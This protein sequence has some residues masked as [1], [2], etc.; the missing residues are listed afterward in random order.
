M[1]IFTTYTRLCFSATWSGV[2]KETW[3]PSVCFKTHQPT[4]ATRAFRNSHSV[5][6]CT[7]R[8]QF[9]S[10]S[11]RL[12]SNNSLDK[13]TPHLTKRETLLE[14]IMQKLMACLHDPRWVLS[15]LLAVMVALVTASNSTAL[16]QSEESV[17]LGTFEGQ[18]NNPPDL[19]QLYC[20]NV[21]GFPPQ[22]AGWW[23]SLQ[24]E[25]RRH[26]LARAN[27]DYA[28]SDLS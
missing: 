27:I 14:H 22:S 23:P 5:L 21:S 10:V 25:S 13:N 7:P 12:T 2:E 24:Q 16:P 15:V 6:D 18:P 19:L 8:R 17:L 4:K 20:T 9:S 3:F 28:M 1:S 11:V 26:P